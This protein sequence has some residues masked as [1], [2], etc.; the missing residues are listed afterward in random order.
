MHGGEGPKTP[1]AMKANAP[2]IKRP[3]QHHEPQRAQNLRIVQRCCASLN[4]LSVRL[5]HT[6]RRDGITTKRKLWLWGSARHRM[7]LVDKSVFYSV[8]FFVYIMAC[9]VKLFI[10]KSLGLCASSA[11]LGNEGKPEQ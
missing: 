6:Q 10:L 3:R 7:F 2:V 5:Q 11:F 8:F 4:Q 9:K 1:L